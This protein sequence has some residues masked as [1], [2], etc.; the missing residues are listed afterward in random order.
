MQCLLTG[1]PCLKRRPSPVTEPLG[2]FVFKVYPA[3]P[4]LERVTEFTV[5][6]KTSYLRSHFKKVESIFLE[7]SELL[8][9]KIEL[10]NKRT[11]SNEDDSQYDY[12]ASDSLKDMEFIYLRMHRYSAILAT[13]SYLESSMNK[14]CAEFETRNCI[15]ISVN[16]LG[17]DGI[18]RCR[19]YM[20]KLAGVDFTKINAQWSHLTT[21][22]KLRNCII[23]A[24][25]N[26]E[27]LRSSASFIKEIEN[28]GDLS[29]VE[30]KLVMAS[31]DFV[32]RSI[33]NTE[34]VLIYIAGC[35]G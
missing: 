1:R 34:A 15:P 26:A 25:G 19:K 27:L 33:D 9:Q 30:Q 16:D 13:Y 29:F 35:G 6:N 5:K 23:H 7:E 18:Y 17:G 21:L 3:N 4:E 10:E 2:V 31:S 22:N 20:T 14:L 12:S 28:I 24:D 11:E 32:Y 8:C